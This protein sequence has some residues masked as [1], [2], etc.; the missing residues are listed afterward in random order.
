MH[1]FE[2][3]SGERVGG[4]IHLRVQVPTNNSDGVGGSVL[5]IMETG[6]R[7]GEE[8]DKGEEGMGM[9]FVDC[10]INNSSDML[11]NASHEIPDVPCIFCVSVRECQGC[12]VPAKP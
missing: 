8:D 7:V 1:H 9:G 5:T 3:S 2:T 11:Y 4:R 12:M 10:K 6:R